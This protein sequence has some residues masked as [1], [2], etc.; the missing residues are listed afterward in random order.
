MCVTTLAGFISYVGRPYYIALGN[1]KINLESFSVF[2]CTV[3]FIFIVYLFI[4]T[5]SYYVA[6]RSGRFGTLEL[7]LFLLLKCK[8]YRHV[9]P[10]LTYIHSPFKVIETETLLTLPDLEIE[11]RNLDTQKQI[12]CS[13]I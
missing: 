11:I 7:A 2:L 12:I 6:H 1:I 3:I 13:L 4:E 10:G 5:R 9:P 8:N